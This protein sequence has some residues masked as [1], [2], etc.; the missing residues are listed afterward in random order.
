M[1]W[2]CD[3][4]APQSQAHKEKV[5]VTGILI[6]TQLQPGPLRFDAS[7][8]SGVPSTKSRF[9]APPTESRCSLPS[10]K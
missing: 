10:W 9:S 3:V 6:F 2:M 1:E 5:R 4:L 8:P 7:T